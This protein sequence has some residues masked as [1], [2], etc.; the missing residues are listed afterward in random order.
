[1][2]SLIALLAMAAAFPAAA[3]DLTLVLSATVSTRCMIQDVRAINTG[4]GVV[5]ID[6]SCN[7]PA[8]QV[9]LG[10]D[11]AELEIRSA[12]VNHAKVS[13]RDNVLVVRPDRPGSFSFAVDYGA[14]LEGIRSAQA[15]ISAS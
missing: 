7:A 12:T 5:Q 9:R 3:Q 15:E 4:S 1:M 14:S 8:F 6:A 11:L 13:V 10:G 2:R